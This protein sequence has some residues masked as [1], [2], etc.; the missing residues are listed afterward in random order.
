[1]SGAIMSDMTCLFQNVRYLTSDFTV[2]E[3]CIG[4]SGKEIVYIGTEPPQNAAPQT[5]IDGCGKLLL[6]GLVN[7]H[8]HLAMSLLRG[9]GEN[10][11]LQDW[12]FTRIFPFEAKLTS[13]AIYWGTLLSI[14]ESLRFGVTSATDMYMD[15]DAVCCAAAVSG[16]K[17]NASLMA[18]VGGDDKTEQPFVGAAK[19]LADWHNYDGGRI[20]IDSYIH[21]EYTTD[22]QRSRLMRDLAVQ[23]G[24]N[25]HLHLSETKLEHEECK[26][27]HGG[28]TPA[29]WFASLGVLDVPTTVAHAVWVEPA[30]IEL[31]AKHDATVAHNPISN[32]KLASGIAPV[33]AMLDAGVNVALG[34]DS[35]ASNNNLNLWEEM[36]LMGLLHKANCANPTLITPQQV[37]RAAT[38]G[39]ALSQG[40]QDTGEIALGKKADLQLIDISQPHMHPC[41]DMLNNLVFAAQGSDVVL[42]M[43]DGQILY[44]NGEYP[45]L[46]LP[47]IIAHVEAERQR[48]LAQL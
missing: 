41:H 35:A 39:G 27:R 14:A 42:T 33:P 3:G 10:L 13:E 4:V 1:M 2:A 21:A 18:P 24:L 8:T 30:D 38:V 47:E 46:N 17:I 23:H 25:M 12:L 5:V 22:E 29:A 45:T 32:L 36:K 37:L 31:L 40:R 34:T 6:P 11:S 43:V 28:L 16:F 9:Y 44:H 15:V 48:I 26:Q 20:K 19:A 7:T